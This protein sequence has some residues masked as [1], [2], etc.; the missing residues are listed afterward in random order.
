MGCC[1]STPTKQT[2]N[3]TQNQNNK[4]TQKNHHHEPPPPLEEE[5]V[6]EVLSETPISKPHQVP[7]LKPETKTLLPLIQDPPPNFEANPKAPPIEEVSE[8]ISQ[9]S[10][11]CSISDSFSAATTATT[12]TATTTTV[13]VA[14]KREE[15][16]ATS[17]IH[18]WDRSPSRK[19]PYAPG[20]NLACGRDWRLKSPAMRPEPS[21][22]K[23]IKGGSRPI[24]GREIRDSG[25]AAN[26]KRNV[27][28]AS[29]RGDAGEGSGRRS[30]SPAC[31]RN[32][33]V[34][35]GGK[36]KEF[37]PA[38]VVA[39]EVEKQ[40]NSESEEV[41]EKNDVVSQEEC[42]ENPHVSMECF[43]FL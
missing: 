15:D 8:V 20:G 26:R 4:T 9:L 24:R 31:A 34:G 13:T 36:R 14:D 41:G 21:P 37:A 16:E 5:S 7:I 12:A 30:R 10:E 27:G 32:G 38:K 2:H 39:N 42:L 11:T 6:K 22:E 25:T 43:I 23:K 1:F 35:A 28:P 33:K 18:K 17:K 29:L 40:K 19:R 3:K